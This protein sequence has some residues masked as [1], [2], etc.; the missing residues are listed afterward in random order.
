MFCDSTGQ[1]LGCQGTD[2]QTELFYFCTDDEAQA[3]MKKRLKKLRKKES[4]SSEQPPGETPESVQ[5]S[6]SD[7]VKRLVSVKLPAK[8]KSLHVVLGSGGEVR[9]A[10]NLSNNSVELYSVNMSQNL[11]SRRLRTI[12]NHGHRT[13]IRTVSFS[14]DNLAVVSGSGEGIK[15]WNRPSQTCL[16]SIPTG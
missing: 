7:E 14:S 9:L 12:A 13:D 15:L 2:S 1:V 5:L 3:R 11:E 8:P 10:V 4:E 16:R 6:L